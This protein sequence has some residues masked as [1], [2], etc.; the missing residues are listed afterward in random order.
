MTDACIWS[1]PPIG[2]NRE[3]T[4]V[5]GEAEDRS[6]V[7]LLVVVVAAGVAE[8]SCARACASSSER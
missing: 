1:G 4:E 3:M 8:T 5:T 7:S 2:K 6:A